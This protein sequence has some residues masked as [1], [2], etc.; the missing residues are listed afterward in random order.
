MKNDYKIEVVDLL[1][2]IEYTDLED[3]KTKLGICIKKSQKLIEEKKV[4]EKPFIPN[5]VQ[6]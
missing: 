4:E 5:M 3:F 6:Q 2:G 1:E